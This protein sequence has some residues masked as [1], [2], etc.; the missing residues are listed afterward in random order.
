MPNFRRPSLLPLGLL[1]LVVLVALANA[2]CESS[3][4][5]VPGDKLATS[6]YSVQGQFTVFEFHLQDGTRC[7]TVNSA[8]ITCE[9]ASPRRGVE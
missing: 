5:T 7:V 8:G 9:W 2:G 1:I 6:T 4:S 3:V